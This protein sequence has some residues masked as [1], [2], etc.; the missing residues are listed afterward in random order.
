MKSDAAERWA[1]HRPDAPG[2]EHGLLA[3]GAE[4]RCGVARWFDHRAAADQFQRIQWFAFPLVV[5]ALFPTQQHPA[6]G[7]VTRQASF[8]ESRLAHIRG[9]VTQ[10][11]A[12]TSHWAAIQNPVLAPDAR[13]DLRQQLGVRLSQ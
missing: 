13:I 1:A 10:G 6:L 7:I 5:L 2:K 4:P 8:M 3:A 12:A 11:A 9:Q